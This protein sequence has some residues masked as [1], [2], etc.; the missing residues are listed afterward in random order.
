MGDHFIREPGGED[1][2]ALLFRT[3]I[4]KI[5]LVSGVLYQLD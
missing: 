1:Y 5:N 4:I 3:I 2:C